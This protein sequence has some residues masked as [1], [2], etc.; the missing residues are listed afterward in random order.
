[1]SLNPNYMIAPSVQEY[2]VDKDTGLPL[3]G[4]F[5]YYYSDVNRSTLKPIYTLTGTPGNY[6]YSQIPNPNILSGVGT[7]TDVSG[8]DVL[9]YY[10]PFDANGN[11]ELYYIVV[12]NSLGVLQFTRQGWPNFTEESVVGTDITNFIPNGQFLSHT[13]FPGNLNLSPAIKAGQVINNSTGIYF[14]AQGGWTFERSAT[15][16]AIDLVTFP[17]NPNVQSTPSQSPRYSLEVKCTSPDPA[18]PFKYIGIR[19]NDVNKFVNSA[20]TYT[21]FFNAISN[22]SSSLSNVNLLLRH[23][24][25]TGGTPSPTDTNPLITSPNP[26]T[27]TTT[28]TNFYNSFTFP[29]P[30]GSSIGTNRDDFVEIIIS[31]PATQSLDV[32]FNDFALVLGA[33]GSAGLAEFP[34]QTNADMLARGVAGW[35]PQPNPD[36]SDLYLPLRLT[37]SGMSWDH[38]EIGDI[39]ADNQLATYTNSI[40][41]ISNRLL[42]DGNT[43][44]TAGYSPLGIPYSRLQSVIFN[45]NTNAWMPRWGTGSKFV[46]SFIINSGTQY[47]FLGLNTTATP[48]S[49]NFPA[50]GTTSPGFTFT[51]VRSNTIGTGYEAFPASGTRIQMIGTVANTIVTTVPADVNTNIGFQVV[52][53]IIGTFSQFSLYLD[54]VVVAN[55]ASKYFTFSSTNTNYYVWFKVDGTGT[56]PAPGGRTG[57]EIDI[58]SSYTK[59]DLNRAICFALNGGY[60]AQITCVGGS[61]IPAN[62]WF[63]F[64]ASNSGNV[65]YYVWYS[66]NG[67][68]TDPKPGG[69]LL[70][71]PVSYTISDSA[72]TIVQSTIKAINSTYFAT[73]PLQGVFLRGYDPL[74]NWDRDIRFNY[75]FRVEDSSA[76]GSF[77]ND[78]EVLHTHSIP[79]LG[80][81]GNAQGIVTVSGSG[82]PTGSVGI[83]TSPGGGGSAQ[84]LALNTSTGA[85]QSF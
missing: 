26:I 6:Q 45:N 62:A 79:S 84:S 75:D 39:I 46:S 82:T 81:T 71:I 14:I 36:G 25:G 28:S 13:N 1:M 8:N 12:T 54:N 38:S 21:L 64:G 18:E 85:A 65:S 27:I 67:T 19:F 50:N 59:T 42:C 43:Y 61:S 32:I 53:N 20:D 5:V 29:I 49:I 83:T 63:S 22:N 48:S 34:P 2:F 69:Y 9:P 52:K 44:L 3:S 56:D 60:L 30:P 37:A 11:V 51:P 68:G 35:M 16:A 15:S 72:Q 70:G 76:L 66:Q 80:V 33:V 24:Y 23:N 40:S 31:L 77:Q 10:Y 47:M 73:P 7:T 78:S 41:T 17:I 74:G 57:I 55:L 4:G 58:L